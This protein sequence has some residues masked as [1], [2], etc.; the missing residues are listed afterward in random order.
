MVV[1]FKKTY[2]QRKRN[3]DFKLG[4]QGFVRYRLSPVQPYQ[5]REQVPCWTFSSLFVNWHYFFLNNTAIHSCSLIPEYA[6][7]STLICLKRLAALSQ[8]ISDSFD[9]L[10]SEEII[11]LI[12]ARMRSDIIDPQAEISGVPSLSSELPSAPAKRRN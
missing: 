12:L 5:W 7:V 11:D 4:R 9:L 3:L 2:E 8:M 10:R 1:S 6:H